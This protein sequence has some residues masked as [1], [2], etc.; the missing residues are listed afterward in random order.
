MV[1][2]FLLIYS[3]FFFLMIHSVG[4]LNHTE[5]GESWDIENSCWSPIDFSG[6]NTVRYHVYRQL[7]NN[8]RI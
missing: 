7:L 3:L 1:Q 2:K 6:P 4:L 5:K 8:L